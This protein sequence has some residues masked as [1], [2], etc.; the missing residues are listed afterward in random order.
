VLDLDFLRFLDFGSPPSSN[1]TALFRFFFFLVGKEAGDVPCKLFSLLSSSWIPGVLRFIGVRM[2]SSS[3]GDT[4][5]GHWAEEEL[6]CGGTLDVVVV[7]RGGL[8][9]AEANGALVVGGATD[10]GTD[11]ISRGFWE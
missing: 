4:P 5:C 9:K 2:C 3:V 1:A 7:S 6:E 8:S 11:N 10:A